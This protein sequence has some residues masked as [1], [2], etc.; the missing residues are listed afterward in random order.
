MPLIDGR[1]GVWGRWFPPGT[2]NGLLLE[3]AP[4]GGLAN[5]ALKLHHPPF[6]CKQFRGGVIQYV[7]LPKS[8]RLVAIGIN[9]D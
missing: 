6:P 9:I 1:T 5:S 7:S 4:K 3:P 8:Q 2:H